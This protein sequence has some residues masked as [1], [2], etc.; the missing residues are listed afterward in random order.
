MGSDKRS[1][2]D[3]FIG[4]V[5]VRALLRDHI[6]GASARHE[7][8]RHVLF[9]GPGGLGKN[10]LAEAFANELRL[11]F[12]EILSVAVRTPAK[13]TTLL[14]S[15]RKGQ[16]IFVDEIH[17]LL[18]TAEELL[19]GALQDGRITVEGVR[20]PEMFQLP[21]FTMVGATTLI[22]QLSDSFAD[23]F[24][25]HAEMEF[26]TPDELADIITEQ[27]EQQLGMAVERVAA[28]FLA[29]RSRGTPR[30]A[31]KYMRAA[32]NKARGRDVI[33]V[34]NAEAAMDLRDVDALGLSRFERQVLEVIAIE[35]W[36]GRIGV[37]SIG[38][39]VGSDA[40][41]ALKYLERS[42][43][44]E[45]SGSGRYATA[46]AYEHLKVEGMPQLVRQ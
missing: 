41:A 27:A 8:P 45:G 14:L 25:L 32:C 24:D 1:P 46:L 29:V 15:V 22:S 40:K 17:R 38:R 20:G 36:G 21:P 3:S 7:Q 5:N 2:L 19:Y 10:L 34:G 43:L 35:H 4:Q 33:T 11:P 44:V 6:E 13:M 23:R 28:E 12:R 30:V 37:D 16:V 42:G 39:R 9:M 31:L 18:A 26:Y